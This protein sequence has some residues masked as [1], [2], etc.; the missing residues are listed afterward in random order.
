MVTLVG[1]VLDVC[2]RRATSYQGV[3]TFGGAIDMCIPMTSFMMTV[4]EKR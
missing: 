1:V 4:A 2:S 3:V